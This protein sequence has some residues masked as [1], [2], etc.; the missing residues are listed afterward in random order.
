VDTAAVRLGAE[1]LL[2]SDTALAA[3]TPALAWDGLGIGVAWSD[4]RLGTDA[5]EIWYAH[6]SS[7]AFP[8]PPGRSG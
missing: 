1:E 2:S 8:M 4:E 3:G 5:S 7:L 6:A